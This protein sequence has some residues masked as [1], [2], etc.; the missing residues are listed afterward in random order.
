MKRVLLISFYFPPRQ[1]IGAVR[2][3]GLKNYLSQFGW[4]AIV[5][6]P[7]LGSNV[8]SMP[9]VIETG[10]VDVLEE[11]KRKFRLDPKL[12]V[13]A[14]WRLSEANK[15]NTRKPHTFLLT[16]LKEIL[17]YPDPMK[18]WIPFACGEIDKL[19]GK[20]IDAIISSAPPISAHLIGQHA[21]QVLDCPWI[22]DF[23]DLWTQNVDSRPNPIRPFERRLERKLLADADALVT[24][25]DD[26]AAK[27]KSRYAQVPVHTITNGF[28]PKDFPEGQIDLTDRF[29]ITYTGLLYQGKRDPTPL[30]E[31][32]QE[33]VHDGKLPR[34]KIWLRF[35]GPVE[36][37]LT[38]LV[39]R[40]GL[41]D[42][43]ELPGVIPRD[44]A[45]KRQRES[46]LLLQLGGHDR[47][48]KGQH[49]GKLFEYLGS[50]RPILALGGTPGAMSDVLAHTDA[51]VHVQSKDEVKQYLLES[52][53]EFE[54]NGFVR[55]RG[56]EN[57]VQQYSHLVMAHKFATL[58]D[59]VTHS[60]QVKGMAEESRIPPRATESPMR[61]ATTGLMA[62]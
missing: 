34:K 18:G 49:T 33:L 3:T 16:Q 24:V 57:V 13:H 52:Y 20:G 28:D 17:T 60:G 21:K 26:W 4:E 42:I 29:S 8:R 5:V 6:T 39:D 50:R 1:A 35:Y 9:N 7:K 32:V 23:R 12:S 40:C 46:Q 61:A 38:S 30:I 2:P 56:K 14:Q 41:Q 44:E 51:G 31:A 25:S 58:L 47:R 45:I 37:W 48:E 27:L 22:A 53:A 62:T 11:W 59:G 55:Y 43:T 36:P 54:K 19:A 10:Y 15:P